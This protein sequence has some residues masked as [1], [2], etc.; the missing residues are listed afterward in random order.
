ARGDRR[1]ESSQVRLACPGCGFMKNSN[2][3]DG[4]KF[5]GKWRGLFAKAAPGRLTCD[6]SWKFFLGQDFAREHAR[7]GGCPVAQSSVPESSACTS[8][9]RQDSRTSA[10]LVSCREQVIHHPVCIPG[11]NQPGKFGRV[12]TRTTEIT[13]FRG[14]GLLPD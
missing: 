11:C 7:R 10:I 9:G 5:G 6:A 3:S 1:G 4:R 13:L 14:A 12:R 8:I 2:N